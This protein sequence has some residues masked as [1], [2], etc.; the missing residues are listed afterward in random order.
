MSFEG[1]KERFDLS[2]SERRPG[3]WCLGIEIGKGS[4]W[5]EKM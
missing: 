4:N 5:L 1:I 2:E 3:E